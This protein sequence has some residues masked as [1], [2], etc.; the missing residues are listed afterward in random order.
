M[1]KNAKV[2]TGTH[3]RKFLNNKTSSKMSWEPVNDTIKQR[4]HCIKSIS[5]FPFYHQQ[6][7]KAIFA[8][9]RSK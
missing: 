9:Q 8:M 2:K 3:H 4:P 7:I 6:Y 5:I 1:I